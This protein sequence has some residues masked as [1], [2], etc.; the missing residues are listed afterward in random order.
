MIYHVIGNAMEPIVLPAYICHIVNNRGLW[1]AGFVRA[2]SRVNKKPEEAYRKLLYLNTSEDKKYPLGKIQLVPISK[3]ISV[4]NMIAQNGI[5][6]KTNPIPLNYRA[7]ADC[8]NKIHK[9]AKKNNYTIHMPRIGA[10]LAGGDWDSIENII[11]RFVK[12]DNFIYTLENEINKFPMVD[13]REIR[14]FPIDPTF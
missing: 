8:I 3:N 11:K 7:L 2:I 6:S 10:G 9:K 14:K 1:G 12:V 5:R 13:Y 4:C